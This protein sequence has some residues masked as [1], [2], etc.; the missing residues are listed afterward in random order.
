MEEERFTYEDFKGIIHK[1]RSP[2][3][4]PWDREQTHSSLK[5]CMIEEAYEVVDAIHILEETGK[6]DHLCEELG[7]VLM[8][9]FLHSEIA[10]EEGLFTLEDVVD[11]ISRKMIYRHPH[12]FGEVQAD[13]SQQV[14]QNWDRLKEKEKGNPTPEEEIAA[15]PHSLPALL[16]TAKVLKKMERYY[17]AF[18]NAVDS[19][20][21]VREALAQ[22]LQEEDPEK[23][24]A[25][26][27]ETLLQL[28]NL[29][30]LLDINSEEALTEALERLLR[31]Y[32]IPE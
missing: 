3:G 23:K 10:G 27:G 17:G 15:V 8:Q 13:S 21:E 6:G 16:R 9:V 25:A 19:Q 1:L 4:C 14:L 26:A 2:G 20:A 32:E 31:T 11:G 22:T 5:N 12:V 28:V 18:Q 7:D 29:F 30:R 24:K